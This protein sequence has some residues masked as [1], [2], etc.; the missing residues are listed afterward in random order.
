[1]PPV[2]SDLHFAIPSAFMDM[3][4]YDSGPSDDRIILMG[5]VESV[6]KKS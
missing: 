5:C 3:V 2:P 1:M 6:A 4:L